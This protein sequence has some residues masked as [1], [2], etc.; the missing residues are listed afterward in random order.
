[1]SYKSKHGKS[2]KPP[3]Y[4]DPDEYDARDEECRD[5][6][7]FR[8]C[9]ITARRKMRE[10]DEDEDERPA[11]KS[12]YRNDRPSSVPRDPN[13]EDYEEREESIGFWPALVANGA[14]SGA[15]AGLV[16]ATFALDQIPRFPYPDPFR[17]AAK[18]GRQRA[19]EE[20]EDMEE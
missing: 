9:R 3:C 2:R 17:K 15:R 12:K 13:P 14:L 20:E 1:L 6:R 16:E 11:G 10:E 8:T 4:G 5:C 7:F 18:R 19:M